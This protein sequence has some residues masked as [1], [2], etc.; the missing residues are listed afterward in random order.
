MD[1]KRVK[2]SGIASRWHPDSAIASWNG[3]SRRK[4]FAHKR[5][6]PRNAER[7]AGQPIR[8]SKEADQLIRSFPSGPSVGG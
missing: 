5:K 4:R 8:T 1:E 6:L 2:Y 3:A 7:D